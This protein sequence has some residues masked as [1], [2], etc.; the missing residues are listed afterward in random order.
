[1][2]DTVPSDV[3]TACACGTTPTSTL[4]E[5]EVDRRVDQLKAMAHP[6]RLQM[7]DLI[8]HN[9]G[10]ICV[11]EFMDVFDL[12]QPTISHH[13]KVLREAGLI[14]SRREGTF[15][16]H[17]V[18]PGSFVALRELMQRFGTIRREAVPVT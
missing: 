2:P 12:S 16:Y 6:V 7:V 4:P 5:S 13:L 9:G 3:Q 8:Y 17:Q 18:V 1:M 10:E 14:M 15:V 11:C